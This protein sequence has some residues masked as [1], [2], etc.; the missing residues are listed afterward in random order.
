MGNRECLKKEGKKQ[1]EKTTS[2]F[3]TNLLLGTN[4]KFA[5]SYMGGKVY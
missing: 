3:K 4:Q 5:K 2:V 1:G